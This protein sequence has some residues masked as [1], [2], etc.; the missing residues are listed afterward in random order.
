MALDAINRMSAAETA[1]RIANRSLS[2]VEVTDAALRRLEETEPALN[3]FAHVDKDRARRDAQAAEGA[4]KRG[5]RLG[6]LHGVPV[7]IKDLIDV[8]GMPARYG[9]LRPCEGIHLARQIAFT[10]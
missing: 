4:V 6:P 1:W 7:S 9:S 10:S 8:R 3:A 2:A 5:H